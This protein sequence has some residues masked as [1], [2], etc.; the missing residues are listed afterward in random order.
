MYYLVTW[1]LSL[2]IEIY[3]EWSSQ[4]DGLG[5]FHIIDSRYN[6]IFSLV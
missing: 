1:G 4:S 3:I 2:E 6:L 5:I